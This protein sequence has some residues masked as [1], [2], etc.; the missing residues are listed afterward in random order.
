MGKAKWKILELH[1]K[2]HGLPGGTAKVSATIKSELVNLT[3][4][5]FTLPLWPVKKTDGF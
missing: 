1:Q 4:F 3:I 2:H 5:P